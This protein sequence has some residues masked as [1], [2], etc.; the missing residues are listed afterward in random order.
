M[1]RSIA[2]GSHLRM[3]HSEGPLPSSLRKQGPITTG[4]RNEQSRRPPVNPEGPRRMGP[5]FLLF[6]IIPRPPISTL[7]PTRRSSDLIPCHAEEHRQRVA[8]QDDAF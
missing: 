6:L 2:N 3:T 4:V 7:F 1:L 5:R 8:P